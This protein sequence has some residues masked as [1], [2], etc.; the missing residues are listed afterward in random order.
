MLEQ[1]EKVVEE[2]EDLE[3]SLREQDARETQENRGEGKMGD[4]G[5]TRRKGE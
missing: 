4:K 3:Q 2:L 1:C 5:E